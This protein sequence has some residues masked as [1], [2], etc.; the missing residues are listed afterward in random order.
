MGWA[1]KLEPYKLN[2]GEPPKPLGNDER[3]AFKL[4]WVLWGIGVIVLALVFISLNSCS[5]HKVTD[6]VVMAKPLAASA[7]T[8]FDVSGSGSTASVTLNG[9]DAP[10]AFAYEFTFVLDGLTLNGT[11][12]Q[13]VAPG[14]WLDTPNAILSATSN[15]DGS[16]TVVGA[17]WVGGG[18]CAHAGGVLAVIST[19]GHGTLTLVG[20]PVG[21]VTPSPDLQDCSNFPLPVVYGAASVT[22]PTRMGVALADTSRTATVR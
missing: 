8:T 14:A 21:A 6:P 12:T 20:S 1:P 11:P 15:P 7:L 16:V 18:Y 4:A 13:A 2:T 19:R 17:R 5:P 9:F 10:G 3:G 22:L